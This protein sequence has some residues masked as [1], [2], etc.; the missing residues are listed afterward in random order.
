MGK[1]L[2]FSII[3]IK[4]GYKNKGE[5]I[6]RFAFYGII[7]LV[8]SSLWNAV[9]S[10]KIGLKPR[11]M[12][13]YLAMTEWIVLSYPLIH[14]AIQEDIRTGNVAYLLTRP[15]PYIWVKFFEGMGTLLLRMLILA[16]AGF[17]FAYF[18]T[19]GLPTN[20][21]GLLLYFPVGIFASMVVTLYQS[22][23]GLFSFWLQDATP[24][25]WIFSKCNFILG[26]MMLP[27]DIYPEWLQKIA[28][29][30]PFSSFLY[31]PV[32]ACLEL[33]ASL[34]LEALIKLTVWAVIGLIAMQ[35]IYLR[36]VKKLN[37]NGG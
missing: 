14:T 5:T 37:V 2:S 26:G 1:Y 9:G 3:A 12:I 6:A 4:H 8:F 17:G 28:M 32:K 35:L 34:L 29:L 16:F 15:I 27:L 10:E 36:G 33:D 21:L 31:L 25:Y 18:I 23:I 13:W 19:G 30:T 11:D 7:L 22:I 20:P 24:I